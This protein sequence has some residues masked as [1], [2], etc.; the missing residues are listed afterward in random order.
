MKTPLAW[1][2]LVHNRVRT[3]VATAGVAFSV[4]LIFMQ[5]GFLGSV[6]TTA[7]MIYDSLDFDLA[8]RSKEYLHLAKPSS[9]SQT[10]LYQA[11]AIEGVEAVAPFYVGMNQW[12]NPSEGTR[13]PLLVI[14][15]DPER[16]VFQD[17][18][19]GES[20]RRLMRANAVLMDRECRS[21]FGPAEGEE[22][23]TADEGV[24]SEIGVKRVDVVGCFR[25]GSGLTADGAA[26]VNADGFCRLYPGRTKERVS[27]GFVKLSP[28][29]DAEAVAARVAA[30][31]PPDVEVLPRDVVID[32]EILRWVYQTPVGI[33]F[34]LGVA[35]AFVVGLA[36]VYQVLSADVASH[37]REYATLKAM[38]Y[39]QMYLSGVV[40]TQACALAI[41]GFAPGLVAALALYWITGTIAN[42]PLY[43]NW[44]RVGLVLLLAVAMCVISGMGALRKSRSADPADLF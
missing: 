25:L 30:V 44:N 35:V 21:D 7:T 39:S 43:M 18:A 20:T 34:Q 9:F 31:M 42:I 13:H 10:R 19:I 26:I 36:I 4:L 38:G 41:I 2:N 29:A 17:E 37:L 12:R 3:A 11:Q 27:L 15:V 6:Q 33:I 1:H 16:P 32:R 5:W 8:I 40:L 28:D 22:F 24:V 23:S 14:G